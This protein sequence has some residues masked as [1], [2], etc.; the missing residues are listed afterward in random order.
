MLLIRCWLMLKVVKNKHSEH[1]RDF[2]NW[3][4]TKIKSSNYIVFEY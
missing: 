2:G 3:Q 4:L 1:F